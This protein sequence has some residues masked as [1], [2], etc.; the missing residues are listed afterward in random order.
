MSHEIRTPMNAI[1]GMTTIAA[2]HIGD[3]ARIE[4]CLGKITFSAKH[5]LSLINDILDM[6]KIEDGKLTVNHEPFY[7]QQILES[8]TTIIYPQAAAQGIE[9]RVAVHGILEDE[10]LGDAMRVSQILLNLLSNA[11][12]I[13]PQNVKV[14]LE[15]RQLTR[16]SNAATLQF[17]VSDTGRGMSEEFLS[18]LFEPVEQENA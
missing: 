6:S 10:L 11:V 14:Q 12:K 8:I 1:I 16:K 9:F 18:R 13:T 4:D 17:I 3:D 5:L 2:A 15:I 7:L